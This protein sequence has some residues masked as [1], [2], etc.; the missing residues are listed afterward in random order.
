[1]RHIDC[2]TGELTELER[3]LSTRVPLDAQTDDLAPGYPDNAEA[4]PLRAVSAAA[5]T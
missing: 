5:R 2:L 1:M 4:M 3:A